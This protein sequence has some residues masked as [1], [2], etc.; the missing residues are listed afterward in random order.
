MG[1]RVLR[2]EGGAAFGLG[3]HP[4]TQGA[5]E[6]LERA[7]RGAESVL[8]YGTGSGVLA[9]CAK[10]LGASRV[11]AVDVDEDCVASAERS[12][13]ATGLEGGSFYRSPEGFA[14][15][16]DFAL[17]LVKEHLEP[18][19]PLN[20]HGNGFDVVVANI[21]RRPLVGLAPA[22]ACSSAPGGRLALT[23]L[24]ADLGDSEAV[25]WEDFARLK[26]SYSSILH[27]IALI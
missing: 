24:R 20:E 10:C 13:R 2:L 17:R 12:W 21:L 23:G 27:C 9:I 1:R 19:E 26:A 7:L 18:L 14:E 6:F 11:V 15:A 8:D 3:D 25:P 4:T 5:V 22:L 16:K